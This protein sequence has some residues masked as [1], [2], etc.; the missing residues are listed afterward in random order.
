MYSKFSLIFQKWKTFEF[1]A[2]KDIISNDT[3]KKVKP[4]YTP[5]KLLK[6]FN[7]EQQIVPKT[8]ED[9]AVHNKKI[10]D[11]EFWLQNEVLSNTEIKVS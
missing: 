1:D 10:S 4:I 11:V 5:K 8:I 7:F 6:N 3:N 2:V 9:L